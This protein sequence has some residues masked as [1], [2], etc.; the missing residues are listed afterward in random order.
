MVLT[1]DPN[2]SA[3]AVATGGVEPYSYLWSNDETT[4][5]ISFIDAGTY[6]VTVTDASGETVTGSVTITNASPI[7]PNAS[8]TDETFVNGNDGTATSSAFG[9]TAP[10]GF[11]WNNGG[12]YADHNRSCPELYTVAA[13]TECRMYRRAKGY[14]QCIWMPRH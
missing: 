1:R 8:A 9:G 7:N 2:G 3:T 4:P 14:C 5:T 6:T 12:N 10:Y 13:D 11:L